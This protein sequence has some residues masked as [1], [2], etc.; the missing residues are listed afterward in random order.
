MSHPELTP[1]QQAFVQQTAQHLVKSAIVMAGSMSRMAQYMATE[2]FPDNSNTA[3][4][5]QMRRWVRELCE[6]GIMDQR[7]R[8]D[9]LSRITDFETHHVP[10][11]DAV[12]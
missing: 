2:S 9:Y 10:E 7:E 1:E 4:A 5:T 6:Y 3:V 11:L 12:G 8:D